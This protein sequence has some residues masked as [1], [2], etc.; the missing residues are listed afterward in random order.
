MGAGHLA[1]RDELR[2]DPKTAAAYEDLETATRH[3][4]PARP[5]HVRGGQGPL[6]PV[7]R[8]TRAR[9]PVARRNWP[10][11]RSEDMIRAWEPSGWSRHGA[12][13]SPRGPHRDGARRPDPGLVGF[14]HRYL[15]RRG[16]SSEQLQDLL[17]PYLVAAETTYPESMNVLKGMSVGAMV[18]ILELF[19]INAFEELEPLLSR[20]RA[21]CSSSSGRRATCKRPSRR[22]VAAGAV[23]EPL[24][25]AHPYHAHRPQRALAGRR[26]GQR[27]RHRRH[28]RGRPRPGGL[29]DGRVLPPR[30]RAERARRRPGNRS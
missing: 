8:R 13:A 20:P 22:P 26:S 29:P 2:K 6:H 11:P 27:R 7:D 17:T 1:F 12:T 23:L 21:S 14:Y 30:G 24:G 28:P 4:T 5:L 9:R 10:V 19:A 18:P 25:E 16:V 15:D 3:G